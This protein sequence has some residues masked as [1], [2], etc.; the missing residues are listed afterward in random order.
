M[1]INLRPDCDFSRPFWSKSVLHW[2]GYG[3]KSADQNARKTGARWASKM[4]SLY[5][6]GGVDWLDWVDT[7][8]WT[9]YFSLQ[10]RMPR[11]SFFTVLILP[12]FKW[13]KE[14]MQGALKWQDDFHVMGRVPACSGKEV[15]LLAPLLSLYMII[16]RLIFS[17]PP[18]P[19]FF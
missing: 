16:Y 12:V 11:T 15:P 10:E 18:F 7:W 3:R 13:K 2:D 14:M 6:G 19:A 5:G 8:F 17:Q 4:E 1:F 9:P